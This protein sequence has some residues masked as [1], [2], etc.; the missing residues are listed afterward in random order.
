MTGTGFVALCRGCAK[1]IVICAIMGCTLSIYRQRIDYGLRLR[2]SLYPSLSLL[3]LSLW[4]KKEK[5]LI[6]ARLKISIRGRIWGATFR[7]DFE[8]IFIHLRVFRRMEHALKG[9]IEYVKRENQHQGDPYH[10]FSR[11]GT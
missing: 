11:Q 5:S 6:R 4:H 2:Y 9:I 8:A 3:L 10:D 7:H 1:N